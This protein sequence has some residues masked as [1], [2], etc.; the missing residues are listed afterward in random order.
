[1]SLCMYAFAPLS[2]AVLVYKHYLNCT[3]ES[4]LHQ[5]MLMFPVATKSLLVAN[6]DLSTASDESWS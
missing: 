5:S 2:I 3:Y 6:F 1:M 4:L